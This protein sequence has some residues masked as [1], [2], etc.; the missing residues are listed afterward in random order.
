ME[1]YPEN[2]VRQLERLLTTANSG[3]EGYKEAAGQVHTDILKELFLKYSKEREHIAEELKERIRMMGGMPHVEEDTPGFIHRM[4][5][6]IKTVFTWGAKD[7]E[8]VIESCRTGDLEALN[9]YDDILQGS[10]LEQTGLK[11]FLIKQRLLISEAFNKINQL[12]FAR[13]KTMPES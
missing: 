3:K 11:S 13:Y 12:H 9:L 5:S 10:V 6:A 2:Y 7:D 8:T 4:I 1:Q